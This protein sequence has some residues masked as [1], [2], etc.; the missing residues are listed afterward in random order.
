MDGKTKLQRQILI[1]ACDHPGISQSEIATRVGCSPSYVSTVLQRYDGQDAMAARIEQLNVDLGFSP[2]DA[3]QTLDDLENSATGEDVSLEDLGPVGFAGVAV[4]LGGFLLTSDTLLTTRPTL[5]FGLVALCG[6]VV[7]GVGAV[8]Y[9][10]ANSDGLSEALTWLV[11][12]QSSTESESS[13][14]STTPPAPQTLKDDLY[15]DRANRCCEWCET[16]IDSPDVHHITP[17]EDGGPNNPSNLAV[18]CPN[19]HRKADRGM[20][21]RS[22]LRRTIRS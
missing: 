3:P 20:I 13:T 4:V 9:K 10:K 19:C 16:R 7:T 1:T 15:F 8:F 12:S 21:S 5:R 2:E 17:R 18:L 14:N 6:V 22:K 11:S